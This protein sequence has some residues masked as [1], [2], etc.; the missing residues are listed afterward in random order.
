MVETHLRNSIEIL[1]E[2]VE[3]TK[4]DI[5][6]LKEAN[7]NELD[8]HSHKKLDLINKFQNEKKLIDSGLI[9]LARENP[10]VSLTELLSDEVSQNLGILK[11]TLS[12]LKDLNSK[13]AKNVL[14]VKDFYDGLVGAMLGVNQ[15][16]G[17][18]P[19]AK[20]TGASKFYQARV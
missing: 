2:L 9:A 14:L 17:Y 12:E 18:K 8:L 4:V 3:L 7:H 6:N 15:S 13:Y 19:N 1:N 5:E 20:N 10:G 16:G 11:N